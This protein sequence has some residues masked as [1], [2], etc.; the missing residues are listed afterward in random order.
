MDAL[1]PLPAAPMTEEDWNVMCNVW[2][3]TRFS[4][5]WSRTRFIWLYAQQSD[6]RDAELMFERMNHWEWGRTPPHKWWFEDWPG[7]DGRSRT[8]FDDAC[9][10]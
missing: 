8:P 9:Y 3:R 4:N 5:V 2:S 6:R 7:P 1:K 10:T